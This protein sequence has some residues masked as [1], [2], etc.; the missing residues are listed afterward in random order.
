[1][2]QNC[3]AFSV[4]LNVYLNKFRSVKRSNSAMSLRLGHFDGIVAS[5][6]CILTK[7]HGICGGK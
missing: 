2:E 4:T 7:Q 6:A 3:K 1:M 5:L